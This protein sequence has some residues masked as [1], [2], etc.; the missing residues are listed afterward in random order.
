L[1]LLGTYL[2]LPR[3]AGLSNAFQAA[4]Q[5]RP[6][7]LLLALLMQVLAMAGTVQ[8]VAAALPSFGQGLPFWYVL[9]VTMASNFAT[10]FIPSAGLSGLA[11]RVHY[12]R[13][14]G[15]GVE[16][17]L[18]SYILEI[19]GQGIAITVLVAIAFVEFAL[20]GEVAPWW[21]LLLLTGAVLAGLGV[22][23]V[24]LSD[25]GPDDWRYALLDRINKALLH[26]GKLHLASNELSTRLDRVRQAVHGLDAPHRW[27]VMGANLVR[28][29]ADILSLACTLS[30][31]GYSLPLRLHT[32]NYGLSSV[33]SYLS[34]SPGGLLVA[35]GSL[36]ALLARQGVPGSTAVA[37]V[38]TYR[39]LSFWMPRAVGLVSWIVLQRRSHRPL[40]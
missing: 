6:D 9:Q 31:F 35:E 21:I 30:A 14:K 40:W 3:F 4:R 19:I 11:V 38:L 37:A 29:G 10:M 36:S 39:L 16:A 33:L 5:A 23:S 32:L 20:V 17:T 22:L 24:L 2:L 7:W 18:L 26:Q 13:E 34:S 8:V 12:L 1:L 28:T 15:V 27:R 25:P